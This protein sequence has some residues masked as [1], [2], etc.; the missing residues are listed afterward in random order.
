MTL[1]AQAARAQNVG[2]LGLGN[3]GFESVGRLDVL[4]ADIDERRLGADRV[5]AQRHAFE[6]AVRLD[7]DQLAILEGARLG[8]VGVDGDV[9]GAGRLGDEAPLIAGR[10]AGA[11]A[12]AQARRFDLF[13]DLVGRHR[14]ERLV[15]AGVAI[16]GAGT[17]QG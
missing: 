15:P 8:F 10:K 2:G 11:A 7:F 4:A 14:R 5:A 3:R 9:L 16:L 17:R 12:A 6:H 13:D 1:R